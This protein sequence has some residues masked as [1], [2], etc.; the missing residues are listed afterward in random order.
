MPLPQHPTR[1]IVAHR[2]VSSLC[3]EN[4]RSAFGLAIF[5]QADAIE[6]DVQLTNDQQIVVCHDK[7]LDRYGHANV[8]IVDSSLQSLQQLD[9]GSWFDARFHQERLLSLDEL[10]DEFGGKIPLL[11]E[12]KTEHLLLQQ[13]E[14]LA[15]KVVR[16]VA[17]RQ[18]QHQVSFLCF[19]LKILRR[20]KDRAPWAVLV[21]NTHQPQRIDAAK[22]AQHNWLNAIDGNINRMSPHVVGELRAS[23]KCS[24]TF[25]CNTVDEVISAW[26][27]GVDAI[28]TNNPQQTT[29]ILRQHGHLNHAA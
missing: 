15:G 11:I 1:W 22:L 4:S 17:S 23:G 29:D 6:C 25:T 26:E 14:I 27:V 9:V 2:G 21:F 3:P 13:A 16:N 19:D 12:L 7:S 18:L 24:L 20:I 8:H 28:I 5:Q 10:L